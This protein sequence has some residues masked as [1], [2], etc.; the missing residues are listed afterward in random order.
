MSPGK[1]TTV[2]GYP[3]RD[4]YRALDVAIAARDAERSCCLAAELAATPGEPPALAS[5]LVD[6]GT[7]VQ[8]MASNGDVISL[9]VGD[10]GA[11]WG[12][13]RGVGAIVALRMFKRKR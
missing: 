3:I 9:N 5:H 12:K 7:N 6:A 2:S 11:V 1:R 13:L 4:A 10:D 8:I